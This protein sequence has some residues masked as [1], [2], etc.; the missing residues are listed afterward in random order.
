MALACA[1]LLLSAFRFL[2][3][4]FAQAVI[5]SASGNCSGAQAPLFNPSTGLYDCGTVT[6]DSTTRIGTGLLTGGGVV[7]TGGLNFSISPATYLIGGAQ[8]S[9]ALTAITL[10]AADGSNP[11]IDVIA[12]DSSGTAVK[13]TGTAATPP[14][15]PSVDPTTQIALTFVYVDTSASV[16][17]NFSTT[18]LYLENTEWTCTASANFNCASTNNPYAGTKDIEATAAVSGNNVTLVKPAAGTENL[19]AY[20]NLVFYIRSK[21]SWPNPKSVLFSWLNGATPVGSAVTLDEGMYGFSSSQITSYQQIVIPAA[22]F[23][24]GGN[25]V[26]TLKVQVS[27][28]GGSIGFYLDNIF[29]QAQ[30]GSQQPIVNPYDVVSFFSGVPGA[31]EVLSR[32]V[33]SRQVSFPIALAGSYASAGTAAT[34]STVVDIK[35]N[36]TGFGTCTFAISGT[37]CTFASTVG[38]LFSTGDVL[39]VVGPGSADATLA[40]IAITLA[41]TR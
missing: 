40:D 32:V 11:R 25:L 21:A 29:L 39:T 23:G 34:A 18:N 17:S 30:T 27:G 10:N 4:A 15:A 9:S 38:A 24:T 22:N 6:A 5:V 16:P 13:I 36:G 31:S 20:S 8:Y 26:T 41:G 33:F 1:L 37:T 2:P 3:S 14:A 35:K 7:W 28:G 12:V 19:S